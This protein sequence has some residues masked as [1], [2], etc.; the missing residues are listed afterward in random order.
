MLALAAAMGSGS[1]GAAKFER[2]AKVGG[3][4]ARVLKEAPLHV[5]M[6]RS[7]R[8]YEMGVYAGV[9]QFL[10]VLKIGTPPVSFTAIVDTGS[11]LVWRQCRPCKQCYPQTDY[12]FPIFDP[13][14][15]STFRKAPCTDP[16]C[17]LY[18][19]SCSSTTLPAAP[20][21]GGLACSYNS[22]YDDSPA[23]TRGELS[24]SPTAPASHIS[25]PIS[26]SAAATKAAVL[27]TLL[28]LAASSALA[29]ATSRSP[30]NFTSIASPTVCGA[31]PRGALTLLTIGRRRRP[32]W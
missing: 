28:V 30:L 23:F 22:P 27:T 20:P 26:P 25:S 3:E 2:V 21:I 1:E 15:S 32:L 24:P 18:C 7:N 19:G 9:G 6:R 12:G 31:L 13:I 14:H 11:D 17:Q 4:A 10:A 16:L 8:T 29:K 5:E